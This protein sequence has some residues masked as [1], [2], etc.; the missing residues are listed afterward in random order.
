MF[1]SHTAVSVKSLEKTR[2][3]YEDVFGLEFKAEGAHPEMD[4]KFVFLKDP[5]NG[6][7][8]EIFE[9]IKP[10]NE[11][12]NPMDFQKVG[13]IHIGFIVDNIE[14]TLKL[15][16]EKGAKIISPAKEGVTV[17]KYAFISDPNGLPVELTEIL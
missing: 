16:L 1:L 11:N 2:K 3:F 4:I 5:R 17:K 8:L 14:E 12:K 13:Y 6:Q 9:H 15:A 10:I 7:M